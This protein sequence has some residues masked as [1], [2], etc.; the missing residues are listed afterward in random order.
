MSPRSRY[1]TAGLLAVATLAGPNA[2]APLSSD[3]STHVRYHV[4]TT[5][6][7]DRIDESSGLVVRG[8]R[9]FTVNDSGDGPYVYAVD[10]R[11]G[12]TVAVTTYA[13][14]DPEDV[15]ALAPGPGGSLWVGDIGDN[16][17]V[18]ASIRVYHLVPARRDAT[19]SATAY[20]LEYPD[21]PHD[22]EALLVQPRTGR[23]LVVTKR[24]LR[25]GVVYRAPRTLVPGQVNELERVA[26]VPGL[27]TDGTFLP[28]G[29]HVLLRTY[30]SAALYTYP[31]FKRLADVPL[32]RQEQG[33]AIAVDHG[34]VYLSSEGE[35]S[36]VLAIGMPKPRPGAAGG[37]PVRH[38]P[39]PRTEYHPEPWFGIG[40]VPVLLAA[41]GSALVVLLVRA[42]LRRSRRT[43]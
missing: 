28:D 18:R 43:R 27:V 4:V 14:D 41:L 10:E 37:A 24:F 13:E 32:P 39:R 38:E 29:R 11:T 33:E 8:G 16:R 40:P 6:H 36:D 21:R 22:A 19:V 42:S 15:E 17:A 34:R 31:G 12:R 35:H 23:L 2:L 25:G 30:G 20:D 5:L 1:L 9:I 7:D 26:R 3:G